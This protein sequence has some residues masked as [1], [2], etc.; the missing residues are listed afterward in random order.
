MRLIN[1]MRYILL[2]FISVNIYFFGSAQVKVFDKKGYTWPEVQKIIDSVGNGYHLPS[3][4]ELDSIFRAT[5]DSYQL[6]SKLIAS[7]VY[8]SDSTVVGIMR[9]RKFTATMIG[10]D[11]QGNQM[12]Y[13][14]ILIK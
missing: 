11:F 6:R 4:V 7:T 1:I 8:S 3:P 12:Q 9:G 10:Y 13:S 14:F 5:Y 2:F